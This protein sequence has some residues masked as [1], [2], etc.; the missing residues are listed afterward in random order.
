MLFR[1]R[2]GALTLR[3]GKNKDRPGYVHENTGDDDKMSSEK[4][5]FLQENAAIA[6]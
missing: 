3:D 5:S 2:N 4:H 1:V 6:G